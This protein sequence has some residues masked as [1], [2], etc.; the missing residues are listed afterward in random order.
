MKVYQ[1]QE[2]HGT[3]WQKREGNSRVDSIVSTPSLSPSAS[4]RSFDSFEPRTPPPLVSSCLINP[5]AHASTISNSLHPLYA[6]AATNV[7]NYETPDISR[8]ASH[9]LFE[10]IEQSE[11]KRLPEAQARYVFT[12]IVDVVHYLNELGVAHRDIKDENIVIDESLK[13]CMVFS[14]NRLP[15]MLLFM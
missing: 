11:D 7:F 1:V 14:I 15:L 3:P 10:C 8:R 9:D 13:V 4:E 2:L 5:D 12:Q 6:K